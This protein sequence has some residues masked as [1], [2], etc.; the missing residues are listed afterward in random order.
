VIV[1]TMQAFVTDAITKNKVTPAPADLKG[2]TIGLNQGNIAM[3]HTGPWYLP[4]LWGKDASKSGGVK[5]DVAPNPV[6]NSG[7]TA[8]FTDA[9]NE[10]LNDKSKA[11][12][13]A[14][15]LIKYIGS[16]EGQKRVVEGGRMPN[17]PEMTKRLWVDRAKKDFNFENAQVFLDAYQTGVMPMCGGV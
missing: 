14:W 7:K 2:G 10:Q 15:E 13:Q 17:L 3:Y 4:R 16:E 9:S 12:D 8:H 5:F 1:E 11:K 6:A